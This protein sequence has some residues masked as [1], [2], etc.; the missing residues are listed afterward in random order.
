MVLG[1]YALLSALCTM[2]HA[3]NIKTNAKDARPRKN[4]PH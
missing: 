4:L 2:P 3:Q 1:Q